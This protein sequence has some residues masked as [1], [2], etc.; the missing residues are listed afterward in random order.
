MGDESNIVR[1]P[2]RG[3]KP[4]RLFR[5]PT[6]ELCYATRSYTPRD[7]YTIQVTGKK[8]DVT[9]DVQAIVYEVAGDLWDIA[10]SVLADTKRESPEL[11][12]R[13]EEAIAAYEA[14]MVDHHSVVLA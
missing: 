1:L 11:G 7:D 14:F 13:L 5:S 9:K 12:E 2:S 4:T 6:T 8:D 10:R 3:P